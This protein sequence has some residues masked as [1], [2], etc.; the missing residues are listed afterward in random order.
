MVHNK[1]GLDTPRSLLLLTVRRHYEYTSFWKNNAGQTLQTGSSVIP[2]FAAA[3]WLKP[4]ILVHQGI[5]SV[6]VG[7]GCQVGPTCGYAKGRCGGVRLWWD[8]VGVASGYLINGHGGGNTCT[9]CR[10]LNSSHPRP[11]TCVNKS[12]HRKA[13]PF[14]NSKLSPYLGNFQV[15]CP[16]SWSAVLTRLMDSQRYLERRQGSLR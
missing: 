16:H 13:K 12:G 3:V 2:E 5:R 7:S 1:A 10:A 9:E 8:K 14:A 4:W 11:Q 6:G 15:F